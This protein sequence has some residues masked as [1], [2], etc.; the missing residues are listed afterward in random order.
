MTDT[1]NNKTAFIIVVF[2]ALKIGLIS[3]ISMFLCL[4]PKKILINSKERRMFNNNLWN[5][6]TLCNLYKMYLRVPFASLVWDPFVVFPVGQR[7]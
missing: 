4:V 3:V 1:G 6:F 5:P 7:K 2:E